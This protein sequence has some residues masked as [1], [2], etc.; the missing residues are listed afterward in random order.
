[1]ANKFDERQRIVQSVV[2]LCLKEKK[3]VTQAQMAQASGVSIT[4]IRSI[5]GTADSTESL[6]RQ[7]LYLDKESNVTSEETK[8]PADEIDA[9]HYAQEVSRLAMEN[10]HMKKQVEEMSEISTFESRILGTMAD[11]LTSIPDITFSPEELGKS[12]TQQYN[13]ELLLLLSDIHA[14]ERINAEEMGYLNEYTMKIMYKRFQYLV[15]HIIHKKTK[16]ENIKKLNLALLGDLVAGNIHEELETTNEMDIMSTVINLG[17]MLTQGIM[18][19]ATVFEE[20]E[21]F[22][23]PGNHGRLKPKPHFKRKY[24]SWDWFIGKMLEMAFKNQTRIKCNFPKSIFIVKNILGANHLFLHGDN[25]RAHSGIP[26]Y[27]VMRTASQLSDVLSSKNM[28]FKN[29]YLG[30]FHNTGQLD[31]AAGE[32]ILN[33]SFCG[34]N[35]YSL[36]RLFTISQAK[37]MLIAI[38]EGLGAT[39][40][41]PIILNGAEHT[42]ED[43]DL[44]YTSTI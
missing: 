9:K 36:G 14:G 26:L 5:F 1:M 16:Y 28:I 39:W 17:T 34:A 20:I 40:R 13:K 3:I 38:E 37:Q 29:I 4:K 2:Q 8:I 12:D 27:G 11:C 18:E 25:I 41:D 21:I 15:D 43:K 7:Y 23:I 42:I 35:E 19:L 6:L 33:G 44:R 31:R 22:G 24:V 32:I 10:K 30:H